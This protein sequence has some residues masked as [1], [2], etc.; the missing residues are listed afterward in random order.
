MIPVLHG[1][2]G[3]GGGAAGGFESIATATGTGSSG[4]ITFS[5][6]PTTYESLQ[7]RF[8]ARSTG[9][10]NTINL[11]LNGV[12]GTSYAR[13]YVRGYNSAV[14]V[15][16]TASTTSMWI[17]PTG[18]DAT[19]MTVGIIDLHDY[20][21]TTRNKTVRVFSG[22][23]RN[24]AA[25]SVV[26]LLSGLLNQTNAIT[27]IDILLNTNSFTTDSVFALYGIKAAA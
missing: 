4:T 5:S 23:D 16:G 15:T 1:V 17:E 10:G 27:S 3:A 2:F 25:T 24:D 11:R 9:S 8:A 13:H 18:T 6:I 7:I 26:T 21:S 20:N 14:S 12:T 19:Y 22:T